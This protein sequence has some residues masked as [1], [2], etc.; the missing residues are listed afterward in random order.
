MSRSRKA[1]GQPLVS[2]LASPLPPT[3]GK[4]DINSKAEINGKAVVENITV[5]TTSDKSSLAPVH[6]SKLPKGTK[7]AQRNSLISDIPRP[8]IFASR[9]SN[10]SSSLR[11][12]VAL[13]TSNAL[14]ST[15]TTRNS[16]SHFSTRKRTRRNSF[17]WENQDIGNSG[18]RDDFGK[19]SDQGF[20]DSEQSTT[21][22]S[23]CSGTNTEDSTDSN[24]SVSSHVRKTKSG[25]NNNSVAAAAPRYFNNNT[26]TTTGSTQAVS[27][28][29]HNPTDFSSMREYLNHR[30]VHTYHGDRESHPGNINFSSDTG[31]PADTAL[32]NSLS[33]TSSTRTQQQNGKRRRLIDEANHTTSNGDS[34]Q[35]HLNNNLLYSE[36][37]N[38]TGFEEYGGNIINVATAKTASSSS[39]GKGLSRKAKN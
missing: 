18:D 21:M 34:F 5:G 39:F 19:C 6:I 11:N 31:H 17:K 23:A 7:S 30:T 15:T 16:V 22:E 1:F 33:T 2:R 32:N 10:A 38:N 4:N 36:F 26:F 3:S 20:S 12:G 35:T 13:S 24:T 25:P 8:G 9:V 28:V 27:S 37:G 14:T 29:G